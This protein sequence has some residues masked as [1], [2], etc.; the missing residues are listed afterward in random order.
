V[1]R[2]LLVVGTKKGLFLLASPDRT[3]WELTGPFHTGREI[4][5]AIYDVRTGTIFA[6][7]NDAWFGCEISRST[8][9]GKSWQIARQNPAF[10]ADSHYQLERI[11]HIEPGGCANRRFFMPELRRLRFFKAAMGAKHGPRLR[12]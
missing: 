7:V 5:H 6:A 1:N 4:N 2:C 8:D 9:F 10:A 11:W 12:P 3:R